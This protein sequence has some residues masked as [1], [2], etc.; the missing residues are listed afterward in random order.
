MLDNQDIINE[1]EK[2]TEVERNSTAIAFIILNLK[3]LKKEV[4]EL[5]QKIKAYEPK[6]DI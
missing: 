5:K 3:E 4:E 1:I 6:K 2:L